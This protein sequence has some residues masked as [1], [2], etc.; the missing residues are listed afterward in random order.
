MAWVRVSSSNVVLGLVVLLVVDA[1]AA[2]ADRCTGVKLKAIGRRESSL[3]ACQA[4]VAAQGDAA[5]LSACE[6]RAGTK[7]ATAFQKAGV[8][9]G[10]QAKC[11]AMADN[12]GVVVAAVF[13]KA[14]PDSCEAVKR[15]AAGILAKGEV[16]CYAN[17]VARGIA[18]YSDCIARARNRFS[19]A[20]SKAGTCPDGA[21]PESLVESTCVGAVV[22]IDGGGM[23]FSVCPQTGGTTTT[24]I[25]ACGSSAYPTCGGV[26]PDG[27][28]CQATVDGGLGT[29]EGGCQLQPRP[30]CACVA[31]LPCSTVGST[32]CVDPAAFTLGTCPVG[33]A[34]LLFA[35]SGGCGD[36]CARTCC[37]VPGQV[38]ASHLDCCSGDCDGTSV[39]R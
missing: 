2:R 8:C 29:P 32:F 35:Q 12:C 31:A 11:A 39:C 1:A 30:G 23:V 37:A 17:A 27:A 28:V 3:L 15:R 19:A 4:K 26:C 22:S 33:T 13:T 25:P 5:S 36:Y 14:F 10:D 9:D 18:V 6:S 21:S 34:C 24:T 20:L 38:C 7:F 16:G